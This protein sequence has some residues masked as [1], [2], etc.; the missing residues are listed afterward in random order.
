MPSECKEFETH[1]TCQSLALHRTCGYPA[2]NPNKNLNAFCNELVHYIRCAKC[3]ISACADDINVV[4]V[5]KHIILQEANYDTKCLFKITPVSLDISTATS[6][7]P[8]Y[9]LRSKFRKIT[10]ESKAFTTTESTA[11]NVK[12]L[13]TMKPTK[14]KSSTKTGST[15]TNGK[16]NKYGTTLDIETIDELLK[17]NISNSYR[18]FL[19]ETKAALRFNKHATPT[20]KPNNIEIDNNKSTKDLQMFASL[21]SFNKTFKYTHQPT[22]NTFVISTPNEYEDFNKDANSRTINELH[23]PSNPDPMLSKGSL[24][25]RKSMMSIAN[26]IFE[27][28]ETTETPSTLPSPSAVEFDF[29]SLDEKSIEFLKNLTLETTTSSM[30]EKPTTESVT[31]TSKKLNYLSINFDHINVRNNTSKVLSSLSDLTFDL[32]IVNRTDIFKGVRNGAIYL[33]SKTYFTLNL[34]EHIENFC[35]TSVNAKN[36]LMQFRKQNIKIIEPNI[37]S[38]ACEQGWT[39]SFWIKVSNLNLFDKTIIRVDTFSN[40][41]LKQYNSNIMKYLIIRISN[42]DIRAQFLY[43]KKL[44]TLTQNVIWKSEWSQLSITWHEFE[45]ITVYINERKIVCQQHFEFYNHKEDRNKMGSFNFGDSFNDFL[46]IQTYLS[47]S[48]A[49]FDSETYNNASGSNFMNINNNNNNIQS[50][51]Y[52][53]LNNK[54]KSVNRKMYW[55]NREEQNNILLTTA[56]AE[57]ILIDE[58]LIYNSCLNSKQILELYFKGILSKKK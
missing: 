9:F 36:K 50:L 6:T 41:P 1:L 3:R 58:L 53:G 17:G 47:K 56:Y 13:K 19:S 44:W 42:F 23:N 52:I 20:R 37:N 40:R 30:I 35:I 31:E 25:T 8:N 22:E 45:G 21:V 27:K 18:E 54:A 51:I 55:M 38:D 16:M 28:Q 39:I 12:T 7:N 2:A 32:N 5:K 11:S 26:S 33:H 4:S 14:T 46:N 49:F 15:N 57:A 34:N 10:P 43:K 24:N 48:V 29:S